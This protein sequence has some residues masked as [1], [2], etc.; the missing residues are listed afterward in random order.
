MNK[1]LSHLKLLGIF[2]TIWGALSILFG[3]AFGILYIALGSNSDMEISGNMSPEAAHQIFLVV[4]VVTMVLSVIYGVLMIMAG[5]MLRKQRGYRFCFFISILDLLGFPS[6]I[7]GIFT[8]IVLLRPTVKELFKGG[9]A[10][11]PVT[12]A[13]TV[14]RV[15]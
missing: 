7:L 12:A 11:P 3:L 8:L 4:G 10:L 14:S 15:A 13:Q 9:G 6:I 1:D 2:H 5:G